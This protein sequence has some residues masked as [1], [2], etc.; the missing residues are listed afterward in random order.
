MQHEHYAKQRPHVARATKAAAGQW[1]S[2]SVRG[3]ARIS[4]T[5]KS[6]PW[7]AAAAAQPTQYLTYEWYLINLPSICNLRCANGVYIT[8][9][10]GAW[11]G[12]TV[13]S[14]SNELFAQVCCDSLFPSPSPASFPFPPSSRKEN[15]LFKVHK[16]TLTAAWK[17]TLCAS[18]S[19]ASRS[20]R[21]RIN[22]NW[23]F[24]TF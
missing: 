10:W 18:G 14:R 21:E 5:C 11:A 16:K 6:W 19:R 17:A 2:C 13:N 8:W 24:Y 1:D 12:V 23:I 3:L 22:I 20:S 7:D 4:C 15:T 9:C